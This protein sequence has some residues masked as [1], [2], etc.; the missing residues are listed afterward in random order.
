LTRQRRAELI[1]VAITVIW[2]STFVVTKSILEESS[3]L[4]YS[5][6]RFLLAAAI[7]FLFSVRTCTRIPA[8]ALKHG[9]ILGLLLY[10]GFVLQT[11]G[12]NYTS[13]SKAAFFTGM[14]VP[15]T[16]IVQFA[17]QKLFRAPKRSLKLG[18]VLG[19]VCAAAGLYLL[20]TPAGS[21]FTLGDGLNLAC[22]VFFA[23]YI[24][25]LD[26]VPQE[27]NK[28]QLTFVQ[29]LFCGVVGLLVAAGAEEFS[30]CSSQECVYGLLYLT[31]FATV[32]T[33][34]LQNKFQGETTPTR[35]A[36][37]FAIEPVVAALFAF[38]FRNE[39]IGIPGVIGGAIVLGGLFLSEFSDDIPALNLPVG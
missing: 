23:G 17:A 25:Y 29:F 16:P 28:V 14:L 22:A 33:M 24:V 15:F 36:V 31:I 32:I 37:I 34:F 8:P 21:G 5:A 35:A 19:V 4:Y 7:L 13:A 12:I 30:F 2:G 20:T 10:A 11:V 26:S 18:N 1:L 38:V 9:L 6:L 3:P 27:V 39:L